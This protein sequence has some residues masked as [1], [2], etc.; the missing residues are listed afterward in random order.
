MHRLLENLKKFSLSRQITIIEKRIRIIIVVLLMTLLLT[1]SSFFN[2]TTSWFIFIPL[3]III[4]YITTFLAI[5]EDINGVEWYTLFIMPIAFA[6]SLYLFYSLFPVRWLTRIPFLALSA[7][8]YY[9]TLLASNIFNVGVDR[10]IKLYRAAFSINYLTQTF[11]VFLLSTVFI[12][13]KQGFF[14]NAIVSMLVT[15]LL[16]IQLLW[17]VK[18]EEKLNTQI[19]KLSFLISILMFQVVTIISFLPARANVIA[20]A[21]TAIYYSLTGILYNYIGERLFKN[22]VREYIFVIFF[23]VFITVITLRW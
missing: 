15:F 13:F 17:S 3:L 18:L 23:I 19:I 14:L 4:S 12:S 22:V 8:G 2:F 11:I 5:Y 21:V 6:I 1:V 7:F 16:S 9:A 10:S 20:L